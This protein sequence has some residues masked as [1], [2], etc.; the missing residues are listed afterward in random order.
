MFCHCVRGGAW[1]LCAR[2][3][4]PLSVHLCTC[5][6]RHQLPLLSLQQ[7]R[8]PKNLSSV[9][10]ASQP[11]HLH[12]LLQRSFLSSELASTSWLAAGL[13]DIFHIALYNC[14]VKGH[15]PLS[16]R[17]RCRWQPYLRDSDSSCWQLLGICTDIKITFIVIGSSSS[18]T[19]P[20]LSCRPSISFPFKCFYSM[21]KQRPFIMLGFMPSGLA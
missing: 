11:P 4:R 6:G 7:Q 9:Q 10:P 14:F 21:T 16:H 3:L 17:R 15:A 8:L 1:D 5:S 18:T 19:L 13:L 12:S 20:L 2:V